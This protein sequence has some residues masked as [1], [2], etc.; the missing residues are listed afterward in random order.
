MPWI[1]TARSCWQ[2]RGSKVCRWEQTSQQYILKFIVLTVIPK[3]EIGLWNM[4]KILRKNTRSS[5]TNSFVK[6]LAFWQNHSKIFQPYFK[7][8]KMCLHWVTDN[9]F[10]FHRREL[11]FLR[12]QQQRAS[13]V[14]SA[15]EVERKKEL[16]ASHQ[17]LELQKKYLEEIRE[18]QELA[19]QRAEEEIRQVHTV[20]YSTPKNQGFSDI[21]TPLWRKKH[22]NMI[23][24]SRGTS[25]T[26]NMEQVPP[27][28]D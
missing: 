2:I 23:P 9:V 17:Q 7:L 26:D 12:S 20:K 19:R 4:D 28:P 25:P 3:N 8:W 10:F 11:E 15:E 6:C 14:R 5:P 16:D 24:Q 21:L 22:H 1:S 18:E 13:E 27:L